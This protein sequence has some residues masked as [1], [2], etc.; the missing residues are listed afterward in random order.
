MWDNLLDLGGRIIDQ[1]H[2]DEAR[3]E[4][5]RY[6]ASRD[7]SFIQRRVKDAKKAGVSPLFALGAG[8]YSPSSVSVGSGFSGMGQNIGRAVDA[9]AT[10]SERQSR[11]L[12][13]LAIERGE[14][15]NAQLRSN[16]ALSGQ[17]GQAPS[18]PDGSTK[19][20]PPNIS[21]SIPGSPGM[22]PG[23]QPSTGFVQ[24]PD[25]SVGVVY[26][27]GLK[28]SIEDSP[29]EYTEFARNV[30]ATNAGAES[31]KPPRSYLP[32]GKDDWEWSL[33][34]QSWIPV[35]KKDVHRSYMPE[36]PNTF[37]R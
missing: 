29:Y 33:V 30:I 13:E 6:D 34:K 10:G 11:R 8:S 37:G 36:Y 1:I 24:H 32:K 27:Q 14:L 7:D 2:G 12:G 15:E 4:Q 19:R 35:R 22:E 17:A 26:G 3:S 18:Y 9:V 25:G 28:Q 21:T 20:T 31:Y 16:L 5:R 23:L